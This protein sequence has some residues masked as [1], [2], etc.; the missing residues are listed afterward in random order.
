MAIFLY[1][2]VC[3]LLLDSLI[4]SW[5]VTLWLILLPLWGVYALAE[6]TLDWCMKSPACPVG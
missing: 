6:H 5:Q 3:I 1:L 4:R 2:G